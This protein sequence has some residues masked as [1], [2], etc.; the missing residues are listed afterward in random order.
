MQQLLLIGRRFS[1]FRGEDDKE[2]AAPS[3]PP[4]S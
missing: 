2:G 4:F 3:P 1:R